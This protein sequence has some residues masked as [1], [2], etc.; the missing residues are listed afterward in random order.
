MNLLGGTN[1]AMRREWREL[2][3]YYEL[4]DAQRQWRILGSPAG[5]RELARLIREYAEDPIHAGI[6]EH[7]HLGPYWYL[8]I[9]T[10]HHPTITDHWIAGP[11]ERLAALADEID[12]R[13]AAISAP[14]AIHLRERF[15]PD[16]PYELTLEVHPDGFDP[17]A[18]DY[19][20][21]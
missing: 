11:L 13:A 9:G 10:W 4:D 15:A 7:M 20:I 2:G 5:L 3:F 8:K 21:Q 12:R 19:L 16:S 6:S 18:V 1:E 17:P 14:A